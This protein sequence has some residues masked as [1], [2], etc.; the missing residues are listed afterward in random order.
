MMKES[1]AQKHFFDYNR[2]HNLDIKV[3]RIFNTYGPR[4]LADDGRVMSNFIV[5]AL[6]GDDLTIYGDGSQTRSFCFVDDIIDGF[7]KMMKRILKLKDQLIWAIHLKSRL[8]I[9]QKK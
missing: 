8:S 9:L 4:M 7:I 1:A 5:Q 2:Q 3:V 6:G